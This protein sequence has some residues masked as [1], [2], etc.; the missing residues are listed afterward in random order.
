MADVIREIYRSLE[1]LTGQLDLEELIGMTAFTTFLVGFSTVRL[2]AKLEEWRESTARVVNRILEQN[3][4]D[5]LLPLPGNVLHLGRVSPEFDPKDDTWRRS[6][7]ATWLTF[8][9]SSVLIGFH[10][11]FSSRSPEFPNGSSLLSHGLIQVIHLIVV[12]IGALGPRSVARTVASEEKALP[13]TRYKV[14][15]DLIRTWLNVPSRSSPN[16]NLHAATQDVLD[17]CNLMDQTLPDWSWLHLIRSTVDPSRR[18]VLRAQLQR[19]RDLAAKTKHID[20]YSMIAFIWSHYLLEP[21]GASIAVTFSELQT[22][23]D[24]SERQRIRT[25]EYDIYVSMALS[26]VLEVWESRQ[27]SASTEAAE[28][29]V[30]TTSALGVLKG[31]LAA[32][33]VFC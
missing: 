13:L 31:H 18:H 32:A 14:L 33:K 22:V 6:T 5:D 23:I 19:V 8:G 28:T 30:E 2:Q 17:C 21:D 27:L 9:V 10:W 26:I 15:E 29:T 20:E 16:Q 4:E 24:Y 1:D 11:S 12:L 7:I 3:S 25:G